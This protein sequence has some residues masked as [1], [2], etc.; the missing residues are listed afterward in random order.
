MSPPG[1]KAGFNWIMGAGQN[2]SASY[3]RSTCALMSGAL[4]V[5]KDRVNR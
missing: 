4:M 2:R 1:T 5:T 3:S